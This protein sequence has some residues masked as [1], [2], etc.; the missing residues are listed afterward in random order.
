[1]KVTAVGASACKPCDVD[2]AASRKET[3]S[4]S[5]VTI[6]KPR[7][8]PFKCLLLVQCL[9]IG[10]DA[11]KLGLQRARIAAALGDVCCCCHRGASVPVL[12]GEGG[13]SGDDSLEAP[14]HGA[15]FG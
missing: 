10:T 15:L 12:G 6:S 1:M 14:E 3:A 9:H 13:S 5:P 4:H 2:M 11:V 8:A 7:K